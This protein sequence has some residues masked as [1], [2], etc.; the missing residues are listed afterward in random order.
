VDCRCVL[1]CTGMHHARPLPPL[2]LLSIMMCCRSSPTSPTIALS[3][4]P[5]SFLVSRRGIRES[6]QGRSQLSRPSPLGKGKLEPGITLLRTVFPAVLIRPSLPNAQTKQE[7]YSLSPETSLLIGKA[8][9]WPC[10]WVLLGRKSTE[11]DV[12]DVQ[13]AAEKIWCGRFEHEASPAY[14]PITLRPIPDSPLSPL[15]TRVL[16]QG[17]Q[18]REK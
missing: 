17:P 6:R 1:R 18:D 10:L 15:A 12:A 14:P 9:R 16:L 5:N 13:K 4:T 3:E 8:H 7:I 2:H 11:E